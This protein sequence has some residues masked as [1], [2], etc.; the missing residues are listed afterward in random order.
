MHVN[1]TPFRGIKMIADVTTVV[2]GAILGPVA[3]V[4]GSRIKVW[5]DTRDA[6][7]RARRMMKEAGDLL[8]FADKVQRSADTGGVV[9][10]VPGGC[11]ESLQGAL[12]HKI[13]ELAFA[14]SPAGVA[15][16]RQQ[17]ASHSVLGRV[18]L[19]V[20]PHTLL[21]WVLHLAYYM[22]FGITVLFT[23]ALTHDLYIKAPNREGGVLAVG[24]FLIFTVLLNISANAADHPHPKTTTAPPTVD[25]EQSRKARGSAA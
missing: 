8:E 22:L 23:G 12:V 3:G 1:L 17:H 4:I 20:R 15:H 5:V 18:F 6:R 2:I 24:F 7:G 19:S 21:A 13:E 9:T 10:K 11:L 16:A 14:L 25:L